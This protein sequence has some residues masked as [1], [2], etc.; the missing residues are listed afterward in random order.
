MKIDQ[1]SIQNLQKHNLF[2]IFFFLFSKI[3]FLSQMK[4]KIQN[5]LHQ[6]TTK[7]KFVTQTKNIVKQTN[8]KEIKNKTLNKTKTSMRKKK[9]KKKKKMRLNRTRHFVFAPS[10]KQINKPTSQT[11]HNG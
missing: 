4:F 7:Q 5:S 3:S 6:N 11:K 1:R 8:K 9:M 10:T 2:V